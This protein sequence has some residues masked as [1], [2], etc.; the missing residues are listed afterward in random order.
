MYN[1]SSARAG[2]LPPERVMRVHLALAVYLPKTANFVQ[3]EN[4]RRVPLHAEGS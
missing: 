3:S 4:T 2:T 1:S